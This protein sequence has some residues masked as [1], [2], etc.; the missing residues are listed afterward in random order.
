MLFKG[1]LTP[2]M[3]T[4]PFVVELVNEQDAIFVAE[5]DEVAAIRIVRSADMV[6]AKRL[7]E[8]QTLL[9]GLGVGGSSQST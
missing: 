9:N 7:D 4:G 6:H 2:S 5:F 1:R 8:S 3:L